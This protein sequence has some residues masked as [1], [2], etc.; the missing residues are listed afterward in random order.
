MWQVERNPGTVGAPGQV[1]GMDKATNR[2]TS[3]IGRKVNRRKLE[4]VRLKP[5]EIVGARY[6]RWGAA[7]M[8]PRIFRR[9][10]FRIPTALLLDIGLHFQL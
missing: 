6:E 10:R 5:K 4:A 1:N 7:I 2:I 8:R 9:S 3:E